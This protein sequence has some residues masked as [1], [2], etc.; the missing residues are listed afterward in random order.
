MYRNCHRGDSSKL[1]IPQEILAMAGYPLDS[2]VMIT[3]EHDPD[4]GAE[5]DWQGLKASLKGVGRN[6]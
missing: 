5:G 3:P 1:Y 6:E 4:D 2:D